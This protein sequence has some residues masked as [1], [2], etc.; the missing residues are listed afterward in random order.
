M[1]F[2]ADAYLF[3]QAG[4]SDADGGRDVFPWAAFMCVLHWANELMHRSPE[5]PRSLQMTAQ[6]SCVH[7]S[8]YQR[9]LVDPKLTQKS[10]LFIV[11]F[12]GLVPKG[13]LRSVSYISP[14]VQ[15]CAFWG[16]CHRPR[17]LGLERWIRQRALASANVSVYGLSLR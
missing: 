13:C 16:G 7:F 4:W 8:V 10:T 1:R 5:K 12:L 3:R 11:F 2:Y 6:G 14:S 15:S 17:S 9:T